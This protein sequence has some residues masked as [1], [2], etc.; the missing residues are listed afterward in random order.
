MLLDHM[1]S[2][3]DKTDFDLEFLTAAATTLRTDSLRGEM[4]NRARILQTLLQST[5]KPEKGAYNC[6]F[7]ERPLGISLVLQK[8]DGERNFVVSKVNPGT[9]NVVVVGD[10]L[11]KINGTRVVA[12]WELQRVSLELKGAPFP[13]TLTM[14]RRGENSPVEQIVYACH[15][16]N[17]QRD[18]G[19]RLG[20]L[21]FQYASALG[22]AHIAGAKFKHTYHWLFLPFKGIQVPELSCPGQLVEM[23]EL[24]PCRFDDASSKQLQQRNTSAFV[25]LGFRQSWKYFAPIEGI[26]REHFQFTEYYSTKAQNFL[27]D[28]AIKENYKQ[29]L[30]VGVHIRAGDLLQHS[31]FGSIA[32]A[33]HR[34]AFFKRAH[35]YF[36]SKYEGSELIF[37]ICGDQPDYA[38]SLWPFNSSYSVPNEVSDGSLFVDMA[39]LSLC[40]HTIITWGSFGWWSAWLAGGD[41][42]YS[43][44]LVES[45]AGDLPLGTFDL[46]DFIP[47]KWI[48][49]STDGEE[50]VARSGGAPG[51][52]SSCDSSES[53]YDE[54][55]CSQYKWEQEELERERQEDSAKRAKE[56]EEQALS[57]ERAR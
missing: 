30:F 36:T 13:V 3:Y 23:Q 47:P 45:Y 42:I 5:D 11:L 25:M 51:E 28:I 34:G 12:A 4:A 48:G 44:E 9:L 33:V 37:I 24:G 50:E 29:P 39:S 40:N 17:Q 43:R 19:G 10:E 31:Y 57:R 54:Q 2:F 56:L 1:T 53:S 15:E 26:I 52:H 49:I 8:I 16:L 18:I 21:L 6:T 41:V 35:D 14:K 22:T 38:K 27:R 46:Y 55:L 7:S 32:H 20:N